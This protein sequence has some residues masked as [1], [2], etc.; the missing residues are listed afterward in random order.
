[1]TDSPEFGT[2]FLPGPTEVR[3]EVLAAMLKPMIPHRS[4]EFEELF[5]RLQTGL[6]AVFQTTRP[7]FVAA[8]S[9]TGMMEA[10]I[11]AIP[12]G[13]ILSLVNG[14]FSERFAHIAEM[15]GREVHRCEVPWGS[16][17]AVDQIDA[18]LST[19]Q[20]RAVT[21]THSE[22]STGALTDI[23]MV[24]DLAH[25]RGVRCMIDSVSG[26]SG[27]ELRFD[28]WGLDYVLTGSQKAFAL[29]PGLAFGVASA[30]M[31]SL[32]E[33]AENRGVYFDIVEMNRYAMK[34]QVPATPAFSLLYALEVQLES[35][36]REGIE[37]RWNRHQD[38]LN[39]TNQWLEDSSKRLGIDWSNIVPA[40]SRSPTVSTIR[41]PEGVA[42]KEFV[43]NV[44]A[45]GIQIGG[46]YGKLG[47]TTFRVG[48]MGD[49][50]VSTLTRCLVACEEAIAG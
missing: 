16:V 49:H 18:A 4:T 1:M 36:T 7:V 9:G 41:L 19:R 37:A 34:N 23:R 43:A 6:R 25:S 48:H 3:Q 5:A 44:K 21:A 28:D 39:A 38:M 45:R 17:H 12:P 33:T 22:T 24:S 31:V 10:A 35:I 46:G 14:A 42:G 32:A 50:T 27:A 26:A 15:C 20:Y 47:D 8:S 13:P 40:E 2:F 30:D 11:R 29:P